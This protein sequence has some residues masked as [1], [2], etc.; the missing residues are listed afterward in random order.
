[1][2]Y[3]EE[4]GYFTTTR[5]DEIIK[6]PHKKISNGG[7][8][9]NWGYAFDESLC[10]SLSKFFKKE[11]GSVVDLGCGSGAYTKYLRNNGVSCDCCDGNPATPLMTDNLC[12]ELDLSRRVDM[13]IY[14]WV[15]SLEVGEHIPKEYE[16]NFIYNIHKHN[17]RGVIVTWA[18][19]GQRGQGHVNCRNNDYIKKT[20]DNLGYHN[21]LENE[22]S[23]RQCASVPWFK[24]TIMVFKK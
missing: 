20:F 17:T 6:N 19:E 3:N 22:A 7:W 11:G 15:M 4:K 18:V 21:D 23:L 16:A 8:K 14:D 9:D 2:S 10:N 5:V 13:K 12:E 1:M 24:N